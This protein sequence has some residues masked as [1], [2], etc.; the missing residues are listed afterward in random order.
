MS[1]NEGPLLT[2]EI[3]E[4][5][6]IAQFKVSAT[7]WKEL[8]S[9]A[10]Q[11]P[12]VLAEA[13]SRITPQ[14]TT[15]KQPYRLFRVLNRYAVALFTCEYSHYNTNTILY[16]FDGSRPA[17]RELAAR[18]EEL[19]KKNVLEFESKG[20]HNLG[21]HAPLDEMLASVRKSLNDHIAALPSPI[22][23]LPLPASETKLLTPAQDISVPAET[24]SD[25]KT[26]KDRSID[27]LIM[28]RR[29]ISDAYFASFQA[30]VFVMDMVWSSGEHY[31][32]WSKWKNGHCKD[33]SKPDKAFR[34]ILTSRKH[35]HE[36]RTDPRP[37]GWGKKTP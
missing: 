3:R 30:K 11:K 33:G 37:K 35:P 12:G 4:E 8:A 10:H 17:L 19:V 21:F 2:P 29:T 32:E 15:P 34:A 5:I 23:L 36:F 18:I 1:T 6:I 13:M 14:P 20:M 31:R 26:V 9:V 25:V 22:V 28:D 24:A 27:K 16:N 7:Y